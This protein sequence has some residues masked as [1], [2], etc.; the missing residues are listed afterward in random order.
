MVRSFSLL[1]NLH[2]RRIIPRWI[3]MVV[4]WTRSQLLPMSCLLIERT[5]SYSPCHVCLLNALT[6]TTHVMSAHWTTHNYSPCHVCLLNAFRATLH[7][8]FA[9]WTH[10]QLL[11]MSCLLIERTHSYSPCRY[12]LLNILAATHYITIVSWKLTKPLPMLQLLIERALS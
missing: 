7:I 12:C 9:Y 1:T 3:F 8:M 10:S 2:N 6:A 11:S 5:H 4:Y